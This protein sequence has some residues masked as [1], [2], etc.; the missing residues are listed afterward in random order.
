MHLSFV[1]TGAAR[2]SRAS[3]KST[4]SPTSPWSRLW[5]SFAGWA[6]AAEDGRDYRIDLL[7][8]LAVLAMIVDHLAGPSKLYLITGGNRFYTSAAEGFIFLSGLTV[9][10]VYRRIAERQGLAVAIRR[11]LARA[12]TLYVLAVGLT[13]VMLATSELLSL[14]WAVGVDTTSPIQLVWAIVSLHQTYYLVDVLALYVLLML[15]A[16]L[17]LFL[18]C[19]GR[20]WLVMLGSW[21]IWLGFQFF[22]AQTELP[23]TTAGNNLFYLSAWQALFFT[24]MAIGFHR[25][26]LGRAFRPEWRVPVFVA[27]G[28]AFAALIAMYTNEASIL[29]WVRSEVAGLPGPSAWSVA[30]L[31]DALFGKGNVRPG[32]IVASTIV[33]AFLF[34]LTTLAWAP[35][36]RAL[37]GLLLP[38]GQNA[39]YAYS[40][41]IVLAVVLGV[42]GM[43]GATSDDLRLN[44]VIQIASIGL[45]WTAIRLRILYPTPQNRRVWMASVV[46]LAMVVAV[47]FG[48]NP[49]PAV[50]TAVAAVQPAPVPDAARL[51]RAFGTPV[52][53]VDGASPGMQAPASTPVPPVPPAPPDS[54]VSSV[55]SVP[56]VS[57]INGTFREVSFYSASLDREMT[58]YI[59]LPPGYQTESRRYPVLYMLH[60]GGGTKDEWPAYGL[61]NDLDRSIQSKDIRPMIVVMPQGD[62]GYWVNWPENGPRW[63]DYI[64][65]DLRRQ[66]DSTFRTLPDASH[67]AIG[68]LSMGGAGALQLAFNHPEVFSV[69]G[70]HS[71]SLHLDDGTFSQIYG[72]GP[73]FALREPIDLATTAPG[74]ESLKIWIDAGEEDPWLPRDQTLHDNLDERG[75]AH[76]WTVLPGEHAGEYWIQNLPTYLRF[77]DSVLNG[78]SAS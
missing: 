31:E 24:A 25:R 10:L 37:G 64:T 6:Y 65:R 34:Q 63:G 52:P 43:H 4:T 16:P 40:A 47:V 69:V 11:L 15:A 18:L 13:L 9:G 30:D 58:Y 74:I 66:V 44:A 26:R 20:T 22:P 55:P 3:A 61:V 32:R 51:A 78:D 71:P 45:V 1:L 23:W 35:V 62:L 67:R 56:L 8:G 38:L 68:G 54:P 29:Q 39:L 5:A 49:S 41:H 36:R 57:D 59:Y 7:R 17:V 48:L 14:P 21:M 60:G 72:Q 77:Y 33:F 70:A 75:I 28:L 46:P 42:M 19:E 50:D 76:N 73:E 2:E 12:G 53:R 27:T